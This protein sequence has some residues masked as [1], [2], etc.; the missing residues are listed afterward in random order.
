M[1]SIIPILLLA[2]FLNGCNAGFGIN[3]V[4]V[5]FFEQR[6]IVENL[7]PMVSQHF[8]RQDVIGISPSNFGE[9][10][11]VRLARENGYGII[12]EKE[13]NLAR[14]VSFDF[15]TLADKTVYVGIASIERGP[16]ITRKYVWENE[17]MLEVGTS[18]AWPGITQTE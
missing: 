16:R 9:K 8:E 1:K 17:R 2:F 12:D 15:V 4:G 14:I 6:L 11:F 13:R 5:S 3:P 18:V 7:F 10:V